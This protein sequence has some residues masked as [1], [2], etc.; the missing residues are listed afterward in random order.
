[1][2]TGGTATIAVSEPTESAS[3]QSTHR[4]ASDGAVIPMP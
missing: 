3:E 1:M 4:L 2:T